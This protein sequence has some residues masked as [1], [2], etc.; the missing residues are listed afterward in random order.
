MMVPLAGL[1]SAW[2]KALAAVQ[3]RPRQLHAQAR[4]SSNGSIK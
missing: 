2:R 4:D 1:W 3:R